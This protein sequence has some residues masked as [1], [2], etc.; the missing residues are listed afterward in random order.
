MD[1]VYQRA[2][3]TISADRSRNSNMGCFRTQQAMAP[4][5]VSFPEQGNFWVKEETEECVTRLTSEPIAKRAWTFQERL[6]SPRI[7]H[8]G[9]EQLYWECN[10]LATFQVYLADVSK[11]W[12]GE[13]HWKGLG[14]PRG[15]LEER[16]RQWEDITCDYSRRSL[17]KEED[18]L[19]ALSGIANIYRASF[20]DIYIAGLWRNNFPHCLLWSVLD[21]TSCA[22]PITYL[23]PSWSWASLTGETYYL[24]YGS[25]EYKSLVD[26]IDI[27]IDLATSNPTGQ[28]SGGFLQVSGYLHRLPSSDNVD[29]WNVKRRLEHALV[30]S[31]GLNRVDT[32]FDLDF[33][34]SYDTSSELNVHYCFILR[35]YWTYENMEGLL[36]RQTD[37]PGRFQRVGRFHATSLLACASFKYQPSAS[38]GDRIATSEQWKDLIRQTRYRPPS[39]GISH[40]VVE[41]PG[42]LYY[43]NPEVVE[44]WERFEPQTITI[45]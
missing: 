12:F 41:G 20:K 19:V 23:A 14:S 39:I 33:L 29:T 25:D 7:I 16:Y 15:S 6:L 43:N 42:L 28:V 30:S 5:K 36:L 9:T 3:C 8:F 11:D 17:T 37:V 38:N 4:F 32:R 2:Q 18:K 45:I 26:I 31:S 27:Q 24:G 40:D 34:C 13:L 10:Q 21:A 1:K 22:K 44:G 35:V